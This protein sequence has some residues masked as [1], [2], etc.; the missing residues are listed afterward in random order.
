[1]VLRDPGLARNNATAAGKDQVGLRLRGPSQRK[2]DAPAAG[3]HGRS[4]NSTVARDLH[5]ERAGVRWRATSSRRELPSCGGG[6]TLVHS[7]GDSTLFK[8][9][10]G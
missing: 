2:R 1:M 6:G 4:A 10:G 3:V 5:S 9:S 8:R 7:S